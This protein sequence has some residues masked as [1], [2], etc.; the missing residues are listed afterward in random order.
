MC[1]WCSKPGHIF[2]YFNDAAYTPKD[3]WALQI[4]TQHLYAE[5]QNSESQSENKK[6]QSTKYMKDG[7][8]TVSSW[9]SGTKNF[10][11]GKILWTHVLRNIVGHSYIKASEVQNSMAEEY[12]KIPPY[13]IVDTQFIYL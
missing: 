6:S 4:S 13:L 3:K 10:I 8:S 5:L 9:K 2:S 7:I 11:Q 12:P 1:Y